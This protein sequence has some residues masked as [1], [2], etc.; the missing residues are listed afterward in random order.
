MRERVKT[1]YPGVF[2]RLVDRI[3]GPDQE[4]VYYVLFKKHGKLIE[5]KVGRQ[6][7]DRMTAA[8]AARYRSERIEGRRKSPKEIRAEQEREKNVFTMERLFEEWRKRPDLKSLKEEIHRYNKYLKEP[9]GSKQ[10]H[11]LVGLD[12]DRLRIRLLREG[13][14]PQ[15]VKLILSLLRRLCNWGVRKNLSQPLSFKIE[16]PK[17]YNLRTE[18]LSDSQL[19]KLLRAIDES[20][21]PQAGPIMKLALYTGMRRSE[22]FRLEWRDVDFERGFITLRN[23]KG[24]PDQKIPLN[25]EARSLLFALPR[26]GRSPFVFPGRG[27]TRRVDINKAVNEIKR[28]AGLPK[29]FRPLH[30]LRHVFAS[31]IASSGKVDLYTLQKLLTH[32]DPSMTMRYAHLRDEALRKASD[33]AGSIIS[34]ATKREKEKAKVVP[35]KTA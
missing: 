18:D 30:G 1:K 23:P 31:M 8:K 4:R 26:Y 5:E 27:G 32:K 15:T 16:M 25:E 10:P 21:H 19:Q 33:L 34:E 9:F 13:K 3:G 6:Y 35:L 22:M 20:A 2:Y 7:A 12:V 24:G 28:K 29:D 11:E 14:S 17:V